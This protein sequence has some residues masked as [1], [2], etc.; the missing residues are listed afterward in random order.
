MNSHRPDVCHPSRRAKL[1]EEELTR[2]IIGA[3]YDVYNAL[4]FG[5]LESLYKRAMEIAL[6]KRNL[7]ADREFPIEVFYEGQQIGFHRI[8]MFV[9]RRVVVEVKATH[10]LLYE[11]RLQLMNYLTAMKLEVGLLL[12]FG[13]RPNFRRVLGG[14]RP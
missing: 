2:E 11:D 7:T 10:K 9:N 4:G 8:D 3:F 13:P 14:W 12:H 1:I 5:F 6:A